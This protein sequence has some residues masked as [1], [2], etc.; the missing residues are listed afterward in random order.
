VSEIDHAQMYRLLTQRVSAGEDELAVRAELG[1]PVLRTSI[2]GNAP[3]D[4]QVTGEVPLIQRGL[5]LAAQERNVPQ[6]A[7]AAR[8]ALAEASGIDPEEL[9]GFTDAELIRMAENFDK[10]RQEDAQAGDLAANIAAARGEPERWSLEKANEQQA[11]WQRQQAEKSA[12]P[13][14]PDPYAQEGGES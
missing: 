5:E 7:H 11:A 14:P 3:A 13:F 8:L 10:P 1:L 4:S 6:L 9:A 2:G 12:D